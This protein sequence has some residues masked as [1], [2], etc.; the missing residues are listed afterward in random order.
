MGGVGWKGGG[1]GGDRHKRT[2]ITICG[3]I[4]KSICVLTGPLMMQDIGR[5]DLRIAFVD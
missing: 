3:I 5:R 2:K 4:K 1:G